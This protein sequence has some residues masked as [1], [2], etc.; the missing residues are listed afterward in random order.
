MILGPVDGGLFSLGCELQTNQQLRKED[1]SNSRRLVGCS[2]SRD[3]Q[4]GD[5]VLPMHSGRPQG[6]GRPS[7]QT[8]I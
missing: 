4:E 3:P 8:L 1:N 5:T 6:S 7:S 2:E